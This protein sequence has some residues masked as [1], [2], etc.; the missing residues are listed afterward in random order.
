MEWTNSSTWAETAAPA[1]ES[2]DAAASDGS[3][4]YVMTVR[5]YKLADI[6][7]R[8][9]DD[10]LR[11]LKGAKFSLSR[12]NSTW[13]AVAGYEDIDLTQKS[14]IIFKQLTTGLL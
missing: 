6:T 7:L 5:N 12:F 10:Q 14:S 11:D 4:S 1:E 13:E 3:V 9:V 8:K 2:A